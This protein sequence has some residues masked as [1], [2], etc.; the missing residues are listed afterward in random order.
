MKSTQSYTLGNVETCY[1]TNV[2]AH[3]R[4]M[5]MSGGGGWQQHNVITAIPDII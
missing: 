2:G 3:V 4:L 1:M 5:T